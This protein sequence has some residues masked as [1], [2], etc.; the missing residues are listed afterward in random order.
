MGIL[1]YAKYRH[2]FVPVNRYQ[3]ATFP[4]DCDGV[5]LQ[6]GLGRPENAVRRQ[7]ILA[8]THVATEMGILGTIFLQQP[9]SAFGI[10]KQMN[11]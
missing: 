8:R 6:K 11:T 9:T 4:L 5:P 3:V 7:V 1:Q 10:L 2:R